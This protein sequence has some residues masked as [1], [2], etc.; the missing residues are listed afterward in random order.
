M[1]SVGWECDTMR[2]NN[3]TIPETHQ[4]IHLENRLK[5]TKNLNRTFDI[6]CKTWPFLFVLVHLFNQ[7][8]QVTCISGSATTYCFKSLSPKARETAS[9]PPTLQVPETQCVMFGI[10]LH[11]KK[12]QLTK[13]DHQ[14]WWLTCP[15]HKTS[16]I[17]NALSL[18][19]LVG[20]VVSRNSNSW[21][22]N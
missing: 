15:H 16:G 12:I 3:W 20:L 18:I 10:A 14:K 22:W 9:T 1:Q 21:E 7:V 17:F 11:L 13:K 2:T 8:L 4:N 19:C 5:N 6:H